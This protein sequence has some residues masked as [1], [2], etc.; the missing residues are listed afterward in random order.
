MAFKSQ[1]IKLSAN[2]SPAGKVCS[3]SFRY[4]SRE[5]NNTKKTEQCAFLGSMLSKMYTFWLHCFLSVLIA[6]MC[7]LLLH[8]TN[9]LKITYGAPRGFIFRTLLFNI[10]GF[11]LAQVIKNNNIITMQMRQTYFKMASGGWAPAQALVKCVLGKLMTG[12]T[13]TFFSW[14]NNKW[15]N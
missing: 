4:F 8:Y 2:L 6:S 3:S 12:W 14:R 1:P 11:P 15:K 5:E 10:Y 13:T 7:G 9:K